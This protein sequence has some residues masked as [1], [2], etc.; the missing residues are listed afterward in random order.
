MA[1]THGK[2]GTKLYFIWIEMRRR[3]RSE[4]H[5]KYHLYGGR[6]ITVC[7]EWQSFELF[8]EWSLSTGYIEGLSIDRIDNNGIYEPNNCRWVTQLEQN[9]NTRR[10]N[11]FTYKGKTQSLADWARELNLNYHTLRSRHRI[12]WSIEEILETPMEGRTYDRSNIVRKRKQRQR[13]F[14]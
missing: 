10:T 14:D 13:V 12:G 11:K 3:C 1:K 6:G 8:Y 7:K 9:N 4:N 5:P 2:S